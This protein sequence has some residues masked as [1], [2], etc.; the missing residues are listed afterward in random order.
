MIGSLYENTFALMRCTFVA[1]MFFF[2]MGLCVVPGFVPS[3]QAQ[4]AETTD[5]TD[6]I[7][8]I[9]SGPN[10]PLVRY[11]LDNGLEVI[12]HQD[13]TV[14]LVA[15]DVWYHVGS[16]DEVEGRSGFA[17][18]F[19][20]MLFQGSEHVGEDRHFAVLRKIGAQDVN[21][22]TSTDRTNYYEI[23]PANQLET[24]LWLESD[25]MGYFL[26]TVTEKSF[27]NQVDV[28]RNERR[29]RY[30]N[31]PYGKSG[32]YLEELSFPQGHPYRFSVI[33]R[34]EDLE[35]A[36]LADVTTF[37]KRWYAPSNATLVIAGDFEEVAAK[38]AVEKWFGSFPKSQKPVRRIL[39]VPKNTAV[40]KTIVDPLATLPAITFAWHTPTRLMPGDAEFDVV[41]HVIGNQG[42]GRLYRKLVLEEKIAK[43]VQCYQWSR[44]QASSFRVRVI[45]NSPKDV[46]RAEEIV[47]Q[48]MHMLATKKIADAELRRAKVFIES[49]FVWSL[50]GL[51]E[52][53]EAIQGY[54]HYWGKPD[55]VADDL[56]RYRDVTQDSL[57]QAVSKFANAK[58]AV[59]LVTLPKGEK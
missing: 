46:K 53:A 18:L 43:T 45:L 49:L 41:S 44:Q 8:K 16:G 23:V 52:R 32:L 1:T 9:V 55:G 33:G 38:K 26:S 25:R 59:V 10:I 3:V 7:D 50:E 31:Q 28:V 12:L 14:P 4:N 56:Q 21:G 6:K 11:Q 17:H 42:T 29:Q 40:R 51:K 36:S 47:R 35:A 30:D 24:A 13:N 2:T 37:Y 22:S 15:V 48:E 5:K 34:H 39:P 27:R 54:N 57:M 19:E 20:H 58:E